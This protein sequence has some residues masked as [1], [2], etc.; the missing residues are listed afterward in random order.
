MMTATRCTIVSVLLVFAGN[1]GAADIRALGNV[2]AP[3]Y[4]AM[5]FAVVCAKQDSSFLEATGGPRGSVLE[6][7][8]HVKDEIIADL[9]NHQAQAILQLAANAAR[10]VALGFM[11]GMAGES[12]STEASRVR[13]WCDA[14]AKPFI[15]G[16]VAEHENR[17]DLFKEVIAAAKRS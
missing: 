16:V 3:A 4:L 2:L 14:V 6:Y 11:R 8:E 10:T 15:R 9:E 1:A 12:N 17:H 5:N 7:A 13:V